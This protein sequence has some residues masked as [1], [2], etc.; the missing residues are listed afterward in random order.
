LQAAAAVSVD[1]VQVL[2]PQ[3]VPLACSR[4]P[5]LPLHPPARP[6][7]AAASAGHSFWG[8]CPAG[9]GLQV[10]SAPATLQAWQAWVQGPLQQTPSVHSPLAHWNAMLQAAPGVRFRVQRVPSQKNPVWQSV[11]L[12]Q[13]PAQLPP[14]HMFGAQLRDV[15]AR[16]VPLPSQVLAA[17]SVPA[18][19]PP[20]AHSVAAG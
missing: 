7:L 14:V 2:L 16:Q 6:Q 11:W 5:P 20:A 9:I 17:V 19:Q 4:Q 13:V 1:P 8:S 3:P 18:V 15:P 10:P 12:V